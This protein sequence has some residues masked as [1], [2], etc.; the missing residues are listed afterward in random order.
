MRTILFLSVFYLL[1][2]TSLSND[3]NNL[4]KDKT[5]VCT[6]SVVNTKKGN[7]TTQQP[8][9]GLDN[10]FNHE[11]NKAGDIYHYTWTDTLNSGFSMLGDVFKAHGAIIRI[12]TRAPSSIILDSLDIF[13]IV[14]PDTTSEN[15][16]PNY[17]TETDIVSIEN[18]V[19]DGG[20]L[21]L[22]A[23]DSPNCEF[24]HLNQLAGIFGF[25]FVPVTLN[26]VIDHKWEMG[27]ETNLPNHQLFKGVNKI[28]MKEVSP[29]LISNNARPVL[30]DGKNILMAETKYGNGKVLA[31]GDPWLYNEYIGNSR[32][33]NSFENM[34][35]A[36]NLVN[37][38]INEIKP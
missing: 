2:L 24:T 6:L 14:D 25:Y 34:K 11:F 5:D 26:P 20:V 1:N 36:N 27:A 30:E 18:W 10:W 8:V 9:V 29:I 12:I 31:I 28:Y 23:N 35:A 16:H 33:P 32:L 19:N 21:L 37:Y 13:I 15:A 7:L 3:I 38:L 4:R 17:I 22:M